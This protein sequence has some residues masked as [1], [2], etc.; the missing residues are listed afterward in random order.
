MASAEYFTTINTDEVP[1][2]KMLEAIANTLRLTYPLV[3]SS[4]AEADL[5]TK[6]E[7]LGQPNIRYIKLTFEEIDPKDYRS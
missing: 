6:P 5:D 4:V 1:E 3:Y 7:Y 2:D